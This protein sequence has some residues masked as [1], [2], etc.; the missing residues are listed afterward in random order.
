VSVALQPPAVLTGDLNTRRGD[1]RLERLL[2]EGIIDA[3]DRGSDGAPEQTIDWMRVRGLHVVSSGR[4]DDGAS[5][6]A[7][8]RVELELEPRASGYRFRLRC[9]ARRRAAASQL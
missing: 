9:Y 7:L 2:K 8:V 4:R 1:E 5:D 6:H 3:L